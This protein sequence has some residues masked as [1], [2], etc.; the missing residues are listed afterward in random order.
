MKTLIFYLFAFGIIVAQN[1]NA[2]IKKIQGKFNSIGNFTA[3]FHQTFFSSENSGNG[4][5]SGTFSYKKNNKFI[6]ELKNRTIISDGSTIWNFDKKYNRVIISYA[7][8]DPTTFSLE[9]FIFDYPP[10]CRAKI[11]KDDSDKSGSDIIEL[12]PKDN[13]L[14]FKIVRIWRDDEN[15]ISKMEMVDLA[16]MKYSFSFSNVKINQELPDSKFTFT[17]VKGTK[18]IDLR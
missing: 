18:I 17:P 12:T 9:K 5:V 11:L 4:K 6:V 15:L 1:P 14:Q 10:L 2:I 13:D 7:Q 8:D 3:E 16:D